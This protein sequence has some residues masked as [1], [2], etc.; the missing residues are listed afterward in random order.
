MSLD[1]FFSEKGGILSD[2]QDLFLAI[3]SDIIL[4]RA[5]GTICDAEERIQVGYVLEKCITVLPP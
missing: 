1:F 5:Q 4:G 3:H 2:F